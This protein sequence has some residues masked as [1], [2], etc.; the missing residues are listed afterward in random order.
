MVLIWLGFS[1]TAFSSG[2]L[3]IEFTGMKNDEGKMA[4]SLVDSSTL[5]LSRNQQPMRKYSDKITQHRS[6]WRIEDLSFG[7]YA[8]SAYHDEN[9]NGELDSGLFGIPTEDYGFSNNARGSFGPPDYE[10]AAF[11]FNESGQKISIQL[12]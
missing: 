8:I 9:N 5:F 7:Q 11:E 6:T 12:K 2:R 10:D 3:I 4:A 1:G